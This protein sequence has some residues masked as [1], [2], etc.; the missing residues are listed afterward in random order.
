MRSKGLTPR[1]S[2]VASAVA[3]AAGLAV[4]ATCER[5]SPGGD[6]SSEFVLY[7]SADDFLARQIVRAFEAE[8]GIRVDMVGDSEVNKTTGLAN[9]IRNERDNPVADVFW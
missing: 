7:V 9:R 4:L 6:A 1:G 8:S 5:S 2:T 3:A